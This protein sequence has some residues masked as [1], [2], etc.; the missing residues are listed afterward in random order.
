VIYLDNNERREQWKREH[1]KAKKN[2]EKF[3]PAIIATAV[4]LVALV[5]CIYQ[6]VTSLKGTSKVEYILSKYNGTVMI[7]E[8]EIQAYNING[9]SD[10]YISLDDLPSVGL[11][12]DFDGDDSV[13][14][15]MTNTVVPENDW[16]LDGEK[17][18]SAKK[19][20]SKCFRRGAIRK[21]HNS[22][23]NNKQLLYVGQQCDFIS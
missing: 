16:Y 9:S 2:D 19:A 18:K 13:N 7:G 12:A 20:Y 4:V 3:L 15:S 6:L 17:V 10:I 22:V 11:R 23:K 14:I 8:N 1:I 5:F 21:N